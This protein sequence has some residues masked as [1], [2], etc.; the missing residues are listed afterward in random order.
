MIVS[1]IALEPLGLQHSFSQG[2]N[3][4]TGGGGGG[5]GDFDTGSDVAQKQICISVAA[6]QCYEVY[7]TAV[8]SAKVARLG[9]GP[10][11]RQLAE[12]LQDGGRLGTWL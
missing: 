7:E 3:W 4:V 5:F 10:G 9:P 2:S 8:G 1:R 6:P 11:V 12:W